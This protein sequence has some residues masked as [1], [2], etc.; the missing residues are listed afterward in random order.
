LRRASDLRNPGDSALEDA[1]VLDDDLLDLGRGDVL[2]ASDDRVVGTTL[3]EDET[4]VVHVA[5]ILGREPTVL[6]ETGAALKV[7]ASDLWS[8]HHDVSGRASGHGGAEFVVDL[9][10]HARQRTAD[11]AESGPHG[12]V[13]AVEC[14]PVVLRP[15]DGDRRRGLGEPVRV[16]ESGLG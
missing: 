9:D 15:E 1:R 13:V 12:R 7:L 16:D 4:L 8:A 6:V 14:G 2:P 11:G 10:L 3:D 5:A